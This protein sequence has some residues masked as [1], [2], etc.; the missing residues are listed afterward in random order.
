MS[1]GDWKEMYLAASSG[2][3]ELVK[4]HIING[5]N[6]NYQH[7]EILSTSL[8]ASI[9][10]GHDDIALFLLENGADPALESEF[11]GLT[12]LQAAKA[13]KRTALIEVLEK[14]LPPKTWWQRL[15]GSLLRSDT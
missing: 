6:P 14:K 12:P 4:Y 10:A 5:V 2:D 1:A 9:I 15:K 3:F 8:V 11:D 7:P 13:Y